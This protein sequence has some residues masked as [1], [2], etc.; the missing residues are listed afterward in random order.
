MSEWIIKIAHFPSKCINPE[1][2]NLTVESFLLLFTP[3]P[4]HFRIQ[5]ASDLFHKKCRW[6]SKIYYIQSYLPIKKTM[7]R[8]IITFYD[9]LERIND[10]SVGGICH[11][12]IMISIFQHV[13]MIHKFYK[14]TMDKR[15]SS[16]WHLALKFSHYI[17]W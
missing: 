2:N 1:K 7:V 5:Y 16:I 6:R 15:R 4:P 11:G 14:I 17:W 9:Y 8:L 13:H 12:F 10:Y 3:S